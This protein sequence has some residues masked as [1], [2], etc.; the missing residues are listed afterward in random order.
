MD[1]AQFKRNHRALNI[2]VGVFFVAFIAM[3]AF[4]FKDS[5]FANLGELIVYSLTF[6]FTRKWDGKTLLVLVVALATGFLTIFWIVRNAKRK[7]G[8]LSYL[9]PIF[10][11]L[12]VYMCLASYHSRG[13]YN[14]FVSSDDKKDLAVA[15][16]VIMI[17][18]FVLIIVNAIVA[19]I[20]D[21]KNDKLLLN[22]TNEEAEE[23]TAVAVDHVEIVKEADSVEEEAQN[24]EE[25]PVVEEMPEA[26]EVVT[27]EVAEEVKEEPQEEPVVKEKKKIDTLDPT[28][29]GEIIRRTFMEKFEALD[30]DMKQKYLEIRRELLS[31]EGVRSRISKHC[32]SY[33][34]KKNIYVKINIQGKTL[35]V[36]LALDPKSF[37]DSTYPIIDVSAKKIYAEVPT[38]LK[39]KSSLSVKRAKA[40]IAQLMDSRGIERLDIVPD[41][42]KMAMKEYLEIIRRSF[43]E[44]MVKAPAEVQHKYDELK[45]YIL[46][47]NGIKSRVSATADSYR[48]K[49]ELLIKMTIQGKTLK[50]FFA[51][52][53][54][55]FDDSTIP[56]LDV[57][58]KGSYAEVPTL[59]KVKSKLSVKRA[60]AL[61]DQVLQ[62]KGLVQGEVVAHEHAVDLKTTKKAKA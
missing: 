13:D 40:L 48:Y 38:L 47:Y 22:M 18:L 32:D 27:E 29:Y 17:D 16:L 57:S 62:A 44:K 19:R 24:V 10:L 35:K 37:A 41:D 30:D 20:A 58:H 3:L 1:S 56:V 31:Y 12:F 45:S 7:R 34:V 2:L 9:A 52:D 4:L 23:T 11:A 25:T 55:S 60:K 53:P 36:F 51:L 46:A 42:S 26:T 21:V 33:R 15:T 6:L 8:V 5:F 14:N 59:L 39:V 49:K 28:I 54:H 61:I 43:T 50:V